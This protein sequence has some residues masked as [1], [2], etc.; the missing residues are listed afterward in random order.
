MRFVFKYYPIRF[1]LN[2]T[3]INIEIVY[4]SVRIVENDLKTATFSSSLI[5]AIFQTELFYNNY[6]FGRPGKT[7]W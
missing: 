7:F 5:I 2:T 1:R 6:E 3:V 4:N